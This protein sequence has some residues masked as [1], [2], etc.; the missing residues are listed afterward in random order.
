MIYNITQNS[1]ANIDVY[2]GG[3]GLDTLL[4]Q[5]TLQQWLIASNQ[6][7]IA[8]YLQHLAAWKKSNGEVSSGIASDFT[9]TF[10][11]STLKVQMMGQL[12]V[13]VDGVYQDPADVACLAVNDTAA[14]TEDSGALAIHV[15]GNDIVPDLV[16]NVALGTA[17]SYGTAT[18]VKAD[19]AVPASW[20]FSYQVNAAD[21]QTLA[22]GQ[23]RTDTFSYLVTDADGDTSS[24]SVTIT[25]TGTNDAPL[26]VLD[27]AAGPENQALTLDVLANDMD[28]D[29]GH[30]FTLT[31][32][33]A[34]SGKGAASIVANQLVFTPGASFDHLAQGAT[35]VVVVNYT[36]QDEHGA[37][38]SSTATITVKGTNDAPVAIADTGAGTQN[39]TLTLDVLANDT[40]A[41]DGHVFSLTS[42]MAPS[43]KGTASVAGNRLVFTP[44]TDF[45]HL[46]QGAIEVVDVG[47]SIQDEF[48]AMS[49]G[50]AKITVTGTNDDPVA[51]NDSVSFTEDELIKFDVLANDTDVDDGH[52]LTL[53]TV[54]QT[55]GTSMQTVESEANR[56]VVHSGNRFDHLAQS[57]MAVMD[58]IY[59]V[60]DEF[61]ATA[62]GAATVT[63]IGTNDAPVANADT[64]FG[65]ED[66]SLTLNVLANDT[67]VDDGHVFTLT[68]ASAPSGKGSATIVANQLVFNPGADFNRLSPGAT[69]VVVVNYTMRDEHGATSSSTATITVMGTNDAPVA[70]ADTA[71]TTENQPCTID[72]LANDTDINAGHVFTLTAAS[73]PSG[74]GTT[75]IVANKLVFNPGANF[76]HL[77]SMSAE[78]VALSY[79]M[80]DEFGARSSSTATVVVS[81][82]N[83]APVAVADTAAGS[84]NQTLTINA[85]ANDTDVDDFHVFFLD[86]VSVP[87]GKGTATIDGN[88]L[89]FNPGTVFDYLKQGATETVVASYTMSDDLGASSSSAVSITITGTNDAPVA[90]ADTASGHENQTLNINVLAN[91]TD[92]DD[93]HVLT[94]TSATAPA[95]KGTV[96][97]VGSQLVFTP[98]TSFDRLPAGSTEVV[99][100]GYTVQDE[101]GAVSN[102]VATITVSGTNDPAV[103]TGKT[104]GVVVEAGGVAGSIPG[105]PT[106]TG[107][108]F[109][110]DPDLGSEFRSGSGPGGYG[111]FTATA[112]GTWSYTLNNSNAAVNAL[113]TGSTLA[114]WFVVRSGDGTEQRIT[115]VIQ[116]T[117]D[118]VVNPPTISLLPVDP[119]N[120]L[121]DAG[122]FA[123]LS[124]INPDGGS[125]TYSLADASGNFKIVGSTIELVRFLEH[126]HTY[127]LDVTSTDS[128]GKTLTTQ[129]VVK[130]LSTG[131]DMNVPQ[132]SNDI[133]FGSSGADIIDGGSGDDYLFGQQVFN[134]T[135]GSSNTLLGGPGND[136]LFAGGVPDPLTGE[137]V[138]DQLTGGSGS[139]KFVF[140]A[141]IRA[142]IRDFESGDKIVFNKVMPNSFIGLQ[143]GALSPSSFSDS[144]TSTAPVKYDQAA[145]KLYF[146]TDLIA[147]FT[148]V[149]PTLTSA[150]FLV[151]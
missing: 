140:R 27:T 120:S 36:M 115:I 21:C 108:L 92:V 81:G 74:K 17:P 132:S 66:Q 84:E 30:V 87:S 97:V 99:D 72:V 58:F 1:S 34:P 110:T 14:I 80:Q 149:H 114:D 104:T 20:Y 35:E 62:L 41:D 137:S 101:F 90:N 67:D 24:A 29:D 44:G 121:P 52:V 96:S 143:S 22:D 79:T 89:L 134:Q 125:Y 68:A 103:I 71:A 112:A 28:V 144:L 142:E 123:N 105:Q 56:V 122:L 60:E 55:S 146:H 145:G 117:T 48:G 32:A 8:A 63:I 126:D 25:I 12:M 13:T 102:G 31:A 49:N 78:T 100:V 18:L 39:Q 15:L 6:S 19:P 65:N 109:S 88:K 7:Q 116:G 107:T 151:F 98:G 82:A 131:T 9:F 42:A 130:V 53:R 23:T 70:V 26:A 136:W 54:V 4:I 86:A 73:G 141:D 16:K 76:D 91:D 77:S 139:D 106:A 93:G 40:D 11:T 2:T 111:T 138:P 57:Q 124:T 33:S 3:S 85:L 83:D 148:G 129:F 135:F 113:N 118:I 59:G 95:G 128:T 64:A 38:S 46:A 10:G 50:I 45:D 75:S 37:S 133:I 119:G 61:G 150:D 47:Y 51:T 94:L 69:E 43:G 5:F 147:T 127:P